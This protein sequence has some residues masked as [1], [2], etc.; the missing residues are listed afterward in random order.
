MV[1]THIPPLP[2]LEA[3]SLLWVEE[4]V[5]TLLP[6]ILDAM[7]LQRPR[8]STSS[9]CLFKG[10]SQA[11]AL[12]TWPASEGQGLFPANPDSYYIVFPPMGGLASSGDKD[13]KC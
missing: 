1:V 2:P 10:K 8:P 4:A 12:L 9:C 5:L 7:P 3:G 6:C 11:L 13:R